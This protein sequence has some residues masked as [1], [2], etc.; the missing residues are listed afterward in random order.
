MHQIPVGG[1]VPGL[2]FAIG[3]VLIFLLALPALWYVIVSGTLIGIAV[4]GILYVVYRAH[5]VETARLTI[6]R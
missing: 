3:S 1:N 6:R 5:P 4:A 2:V